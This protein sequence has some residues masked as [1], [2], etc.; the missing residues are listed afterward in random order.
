MNKWLNR[1]PRE[2][3]YSIPKV[4]L[5]N[6]KPHQSRLKGIKQS[7]ASPLGTFVTLRKVYT[8]GITPQEF[9]SATSPKGEHLFWT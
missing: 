4:L 7:S 3:G 1:K 6:P 2:K 5:S 8:V 9:L